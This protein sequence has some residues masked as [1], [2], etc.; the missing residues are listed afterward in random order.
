M[1]QAINDIRERLDLIEKHIGIQGMR[2]FLLVQFLVN[3]FNICTESSYVI[4]QEKIG[5]SFGR[6]TNFLQNNFQDFNRASVLY[7][8]SV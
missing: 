5:F 8:I 6:M 7:L 2:F 1:Q 3:S 4:K